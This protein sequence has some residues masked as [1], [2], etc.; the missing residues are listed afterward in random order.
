ML[1][2]QSVMVCPE[3]ILANDIPKQIMSVK[4]YCREEIVPNLW[5]FNCISH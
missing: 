3:D 2:G 5:K 1:V 4:K